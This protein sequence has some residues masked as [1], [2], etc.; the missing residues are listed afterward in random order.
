M[1]FM[2]NFVRR[3]QEVIKFNDNS[4]LKQISYLSPSRLFSTYLS[5]LATM[6][7][8]EEKNQSRYDF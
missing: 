7:E 4:N 1:Q 8:S 3:N 2:Q 5:C 6:N